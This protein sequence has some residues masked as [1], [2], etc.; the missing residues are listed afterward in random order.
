M[1]KMLSHIIEYTHSKK[2]GKHYVRYWKVL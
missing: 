2:D 1:K